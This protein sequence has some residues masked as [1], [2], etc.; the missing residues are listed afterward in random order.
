[1]RKHLWVQIP[2]RALCDS[3]KKTI[4]VFGNP[5]LEQDSLPLKL[6]PKLK[7]EF[8][9]IVFKEFDSVEDLQAEGRSLLIIDSVQGIKKVQLISNIDSIITEKIYS[10]HDFDLGQS[11]KLLKK[12]NMI[13]EVNI[14]GVPMKMKEQE[15]FSQLK[16]LIKST[17]FSRNG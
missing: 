6:L 14:F 11:L 8:P 16:K 4:H 5:L 13:D 3:M 2:L 7:K 1:V 10:L 12:M 9:Q 17:L 15:A